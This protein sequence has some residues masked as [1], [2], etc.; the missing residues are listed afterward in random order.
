[1]HKI[2]QLQ[3]NL[4]IAACL[5]VALLSIGMDP[6]LS[7][8]M[9]LG[10]LSLVVILGV[11]HGSLDV[12]FAKQTYQLVHIAKWLK[13]LGFYS[14]ASLLIIAL[15]MLV[16]GF[17]FVVFLILSAIHFADDIN[18][19]GHQLL[20]LSYGFAVITL[21]GVTHGAELTKL[22]GMIIDV[23][24]AQ[25]IAL[26][27]KYAGLLLLFL[28]PIQFF[29]NKVNFR[30]QIEVIAISILFLIATPILAFTIY[31][32]FMHSGRH[33]VRSHFFLNSF[34]KQEF[35]YA[36]ILPTMAV[37]LMGVCIW[38]FKLTPSFEK[39]LIQIIFVGLAALT[40]PHAWVLNKAK[41]SKWATSSF[42]K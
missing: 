17:F 20:K 13:F 42:N 27:S 12:L 14:A 40:V 8:T 33:L 24:L 15:W 21:P 18:L 26:V 36:L 5:I 41:F 31:F 10:A 9:L 30:S 6:H 22:Y 28:L 7:S 2:L 35:I 1:M 23:E 32:C 25:S 39:D 16:P 34:K 37:I 29:A 4:A 19:S 11:P 3:S 38:Y